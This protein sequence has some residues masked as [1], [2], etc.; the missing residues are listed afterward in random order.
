MKPLTIA[1]GAQHE[2][3]AVALYAKSYAYYIIHATL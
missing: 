3:V 2:S 1:E